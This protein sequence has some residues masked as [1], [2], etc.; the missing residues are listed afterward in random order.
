MW[1]KIALI[2][3]GLGSLVLVGWAAWVFFSDAEVPLLIKI[4]IG[5]VGAGIIILIT[6]VIKD[7]LA[8]A[9]TENFKGVER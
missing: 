1:Q 8:K 4:T 6:V 3:I 7:R 9:K 2:L 5:A